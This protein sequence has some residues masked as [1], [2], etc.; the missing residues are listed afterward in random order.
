MT[1]VTTP[2]APPLDPELAAALALALPS[3]PSPITMEDVPV[4]RAEEAQVALA[5][6]EQ[7]KER[8]LVVVEGKATSAD[9]TAVPVSVLHRKD[10]VPSSPLI[11]YIH[12]GG[13]MMGNR[14][15]AADVLFD[16]IEH[17]NAV[18]ATV[19]YRLAP[20]HPYPAPQEDC[21]AGLLW[22]EENAAR[23]GVNV[24]AGM[25]AGI[26]AGGGL[27]ASVCLMARDRG[28]PRMS[29]QLLLAP[30]LDDRNDSISA[31]Q[32][33]RGMWN[34]QENELGWRSLLGD[35]HGSEEVPYFAAPARCEDLSGL[36][37][38]FVDVGSAEVFRDEAVDFASRIWAAGGQAELHVWSGGFHGF[39]TFEHTALARASSGVVRSWMNRTLSRTSRA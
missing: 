14:W 33:P 28:G 26:S 32:Y 1:R 4:K 29:S 23:L 9:G 11:Y 21:F 10:R 5:V 37:P 27:A 24:E 25:I 39:Q 8:D 20:E 15:S 12:G 13:M 36:P 31:Q 16:W 38:A 19:E 3:D 17:Y 22:L 2:P 35:L 30:M 7:I 34:R 6:L 18:V